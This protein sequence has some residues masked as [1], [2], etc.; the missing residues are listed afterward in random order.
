MRL[1]DEVV[2]TE[3]MQAAWKWLAS[4]RKDSHHNNDYWHLCHHRQELEPTIIEQIRNGSYLFSPRKQYNS[5]SVLLAEDALVI[6]AISL[7]LTED[8]CPRLSKNCYH[9]AGNGGAKGCVNAVS[10]CVDEY[11][12]V[13]RSDVNSYY[14]TIDHGILQRQLRALIPCETTLTL[15]NRMLDRLDD[16]NGELHKVVI[17]L[18]K[19]NPISPLLGAV[20]LQ[21]LD[22]ALGEYCQ[23]HD[24]FYGR[25]MDD[26]VILCRTR[27]QLRTAVR[28]MNRV[29]DAVKMTKHPFKTYIGRL[30]TTGFD[31]LG[32][33]IG[34]RLINGLTIAWMTWANHRDKLNQ[35]YE[36][37]VSG[38]DIGRYV[39]WWRR[40]VEGWEL[41]FLLNLKS[42][43]LLR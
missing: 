31:F 18:S 33:R 41:G 43:H 15:L 3:N 40:W 23:K 37:G 17:G 4:R 1:I 32:Y 11:R 27:N 22:E 7:V 34:N 9:L 26:W 6:K 2:S 19:G 29:L 21:P 10:E 16:V 28:I 42:N 24:L 20:Y 5:C 36:Q 12:F 25:F 35:L 39:E 38:K 30:R 13:C 8:L 14:A